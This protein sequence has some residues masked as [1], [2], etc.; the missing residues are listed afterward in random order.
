M[1]VDLA[2]VEV[3]PS[4]CAVT[5]RSHQTGDTP[6]AGGIGWDEQFA[7]ALLSGTFRDPA[8]PGGTPACNS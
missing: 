2:A 4:G 1:V 3:T 7:N 5:T 6:G 8:G